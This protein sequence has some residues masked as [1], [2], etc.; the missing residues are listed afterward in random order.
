MFERKFANSEE[1]ALCWQWNLYGVSTEFS[2]ARCIWQKWIIYP[3]TMARGPMQLHR[4]HR[5]KA[6]PADCTPPCCLL[7]ISWSF[8]GFRFV[9]INFYSVAVYALRSIHSIFSV[10]ASETISN[11]FLIPFRF[12]NMFLKD[13][14]YWYSYKHTSLPKLCLSTLKINVKLHLATN[15]SYDKWQRSKKGDSTLIVQ[16]S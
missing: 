3:N 4:L 2:S 14:M 11:I 7:K 5:L 6:G 9:L 15:S 8:E 13:E 12:L 10:I 1:S 16:V